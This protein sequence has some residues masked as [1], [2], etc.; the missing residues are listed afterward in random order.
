MHAPE[1]HGRCALQRLPAATISEIE[2]EQTLRPYEEPRCFLPLD[3][4]VLTGRLSI[5]ISSIYIYTG[6]HTRAL[7]FGF[8]SPEARTRGTAERRLSYASEV[9]V[10]WADTGCTAAL[11]TSGVPSW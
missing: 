9:S 8:H 5:S 4:R 7:P 1:A 6:T 10:A 3:H 11:C 2:R